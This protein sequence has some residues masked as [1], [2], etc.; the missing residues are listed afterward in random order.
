MGKIMKKMCW[1]AVV[2]VG[3]ASFALQGCSFSDSSRS[4]S[5]SSSSP[6]RSSSGGEV[7]EEKRT[8]YMNEIAVFTDSLV[9]TKV[10]SDDFMRGIS[11]IAERY[12]ITD[13]EFYKYTYIAIGMGLKYAGIPEE[14]I[15]TLPIL[16]QMTGPRYAMKK[17]IIEGYRSVKSKK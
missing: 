8:S 14:S 16:D 3:L 11:R 2:L 4:F 9:N 6:F 17:Y 1:L 7:T 15:E 10:S 5:K 13:W 12:G